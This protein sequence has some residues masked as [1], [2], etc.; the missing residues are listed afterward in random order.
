MVHVEVIDR[1]AIRPPNIQQASADAP[2]HRISCRN[3]HKTK[4][5]WGCGVWLRWA[6]WCGSWRLARKFSS[7]TSPVRN[8]V[9]LDARKLSTPTPSLA[10]YCILRVFFTPAH[11]R[12]MRELMFL[13]ILIGFS[14]LATVIP[15]PDNEHRILSKV[16]KNLRFLNICILYSLL[17]ESLIYSIVL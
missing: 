16:R 4:K 2:Q 10:I 11:F 1:K 7:F 17:N 12:K 15:K 13:Q 8:V 3:R 6:C 5:R 14:V 9:R